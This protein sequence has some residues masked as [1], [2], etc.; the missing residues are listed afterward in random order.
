MTAIKA[1]PQGRKL[2]RPTTPPARGGG[3]RHL[4]TYRGRTQLMS[5]WADEAGQKRKAFTSRFT[6]AVAGGATEEQAME[7]AMNAPKSAGGGK[8]A[9]DRVAMRR[10]LLY[11]IVEEQKPVTVRQVFYQA[12]VHLP[13]WIAKDD[14]GYKMVA[15]DLGILRKS[16][17]MPYEWIVDNTRR[18]IR[19]YAYDSVGEALAE[20]ANNYRANL[21]KKG[22]MDCVV[23]VWLEKDALSG[24]VDDVTLGYG[25]PLMVA[26]G[27]SSLSY[28]HGE[29]ELIKDETRPVF[30]YLLGDFDPSGVNAHEEIERALREMAPDVDFT[31][32]RIGVTLEQSLKLPNR[33]TKGKDSRAKE[34][35]RKKIRSCELDAIE[36]KK[37]RK[38][39]ED[40]INIHMP[41]DRRDELRKYEADDCATIKAVAVE[42][43]YIDPDLDDLDFDFGD[44]A[45]D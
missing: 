4:L 28:L 27:Y 10:A 24:V 23:Q 9:M 40:A 33:P 34:W 22:S 18:T 17:V 36:P 25:V 12:E 41:K 5:A 35:I 43:G 7:T 32:K 29:A 31:F 6:R 11:K 19:G 44:D 38:M 45:D 14:N 21:W 1:R 3:R 26:R 8:E 37:L 13:Q 15:H 42:Q 30:V 2:P 16:G 20:T 39:V